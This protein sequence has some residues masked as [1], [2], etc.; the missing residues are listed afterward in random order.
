MVFL[1]KED[2]TATFDDKS[3]VADRKWLEPS[4]EAAHVFR[5][6][7]LTGPA[8]MKDSML[9]DL[10]ANQQYQSYLKSCS[11]WQGK[12]GRPLQRRAIAWGG[13]DYTGFMASFLGARAEA[14][15]YRSRRNK[16]R[17]IDD[18]RQEKDDLSGKE[19]KD[20]QQKMLDDVRAALAAAAAAAAA[21]VRPIAH[22]RAP[23]F[24]RSLGCCFVK[25]V[26][27]ANRWRLK[28]RRARR[29]LTSMTRSPTKAAALAL[30]SRRRSCRTGRRL[31]PRM[32]ACTGPTRSRRRRR[33]RSHRT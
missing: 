13:E 33:G 17:M 19:H 6:D 12:F 21:A 14:L 25:R 16:N 1:V 18:T 15:L 26:V 10:E 5:L 11:K 23:L 7:K 3:F 4:A 2:K 30:R 8:R 24:A 32:G 22:N 27:L 31:R 9:R 28:R 20:L 29:L